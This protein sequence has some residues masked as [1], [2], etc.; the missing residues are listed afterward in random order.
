MAYVSSESG[1]NEVYVRP[2][3]SGEGKWQVSIAGGIE[4]TWRGDGTEIFYIAENRQ[5]MAVP[6]KTGATVEAGA[7]VPLFDTAM[8]SNP[9]PG[10]TRNQYAVTADGQ[11]FL[12]N[13]QADGAFPAPIMVVVNWPAT[14]KK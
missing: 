2:F 8:S 11:R 14:L 9:N 3:P 5:L 4:P 13:Q 12:V 1:R 7:P 10:Y 6:I